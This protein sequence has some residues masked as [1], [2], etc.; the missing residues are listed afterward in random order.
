MN[1]V[2]CSW[3]FANMY[4]IPWP[5]RRVH[6]YIRQSINSSTRFLSVPSL[7]VEAWYT[8]RLHQQMLSDIRRSLASVEEKDVPP[9]LPPFFSCKDARQASLWQNP[10]TM[11]SLLP[12]ER[13]LCRLG[14]G[15]GSGLRR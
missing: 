11:R 3:L 14:S 4:P 7:F 5:D 9:A 12:Q 15:R 6:L 10:K 2:L 1:A 8:Q 13:K